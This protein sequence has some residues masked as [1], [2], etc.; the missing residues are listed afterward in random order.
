MGRGPAAGDDERA[1]RI[2]TPLPGR[3]ASC[4]SVRPRKTSPERL[5]SSAGAGH[6]PT[7]QQ[8]SRTRKGESL[9]PDP[10]P[11]R[12]AGR[13]PFASLVEA[14]AQSLR[15]VEEADDNSIGLIREV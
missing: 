1:D 4:R 6:P 15:D 13:P 11:D 12:I 3:P 8:R 7:D 9:D 14:G 10:D 5:P 2:A